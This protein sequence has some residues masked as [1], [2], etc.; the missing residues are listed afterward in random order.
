MK[1][2]NPASLT[3]LLLAIPFIQAIIWP[4][5]NINFIYKTSVAI[6][7][8]EFLTLHSSLML[9]GY[10]NGGIKTK[11]G[12]N[13]GILPIFAAYMLMLYTTSVSLKSYIIFATA[14]FSFAIKFFIDRQSPDPL[15]Q[16]KS[17]VAYMSSI[18]TVILFSF[19]LPFLIPLPQEVFLAK[20]LNTSGLFVDTPQTILV[21][22]ILYPIYLVL[23]ENIKLKTKDLPNS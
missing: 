19:L 17:T 3:N 15:R 18:F 20:P 14:A 1:L 6:M 8:V 9:F 4:T 5:Q 22:G 11:G 16:I 7:I 10:K 13:I 12:K 21:W 23:I 2:Q